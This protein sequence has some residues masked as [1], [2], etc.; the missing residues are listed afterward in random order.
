VAGHIAVEVDY[1]LIGGV[2]VDDVPGLLKRGLGALDEGWVG[3]PQAQLVDDD[4]SRDGL[5]A[6]PRIQ[7]QKRRQGSERPTDGAKNRQ[8]PKT[9]AP[10]LS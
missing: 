6:W 8:Q 7:R 1:D 2:V 5:P 3:L 4:G 9:T 10:P